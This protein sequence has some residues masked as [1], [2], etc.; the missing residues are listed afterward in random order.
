M[1]RAI[2]SNWGLPR[3]AGFLSAGRTDDGSRERNV[4]QTSD[5]DLARLAARGDHAAF[6]KLVVRHAKALFQVAISLSATRP[7]AEDLVQETFAAAYKGL[8]AF[9][10]RAS[11][12]TW[13][14]RILMRRAA[15]AWRAGRHR[16]KSV[17]LDAAPPPARESSE[18][19]VDQR[20]DLS[21][22]LQ[23]LDEN[24]REV[25]V[26]REMQGL[27]YAQIAQTLGLPQGTVESR[28]HRARAEL[29]QRLKGYGYFTQRTGNSD[30]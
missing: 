24:H 28:L 13:M 20:L 15:D 7:D 21:E 22:V 12:R 4:L 16:R 6:H 30:Q 23:Q 26:L 11:V 14:T 1:S 25:I 29:R 10:G 17:N 27:S 9:D 19:I 8:P 2:G 5:L 18:S 3:M